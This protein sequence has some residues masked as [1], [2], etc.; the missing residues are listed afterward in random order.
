MFNN[1]VYLDE[2][3]ICGQKFEGTKFQKSS[4]R[5]KHLQLV[6]KITYEQYVIDNF[7]NGVR[8]TCGCGCGEF[9]KFRRQFVDNSWFFTYCQNHRPSK[10]HTQEHKDKIGRGC[11]KTMLEK[12]GVTNPMAVP[13]FKKKQQD[14]VFK[15]YGCTNP[16]KNDK[17]KEKGKKTML[18]RYGV[19]YALQSPEIQKKFKRTSLKKFGVEHPFESEIVKDK[20]KDTIQEKYGSDYY[21]S[22]QEFKDKSIKHFREKYGVDNIMKVKYYID[23]C[24]KNSKKVRFEKYGVEYFLQLPNYKKLYCTSHK[25]KKEIELC[26]K[27]G[28][29]SGFWFNGKEYDIKVGNNLFEIDGD[30]YHV[31]E[32]KNLNLPQLNSCVNDFNKINDCKESPY[33][34]YKIF[35][36]NLPKEIT[37]ENLIK[38]SYVPNF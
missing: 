7:Y 13:K 21:T 14:E 28:G 17:V 5:G 9:P 38:N 6:H 26:E 35:I 29:E 23:L 33:N 1:M 34:L 4:I 10:P 19:E 20:I 25:S 30:Y 31:K 18:K 12:Y 15:K 24:T 22:T 2:C 11:K 8:P 37:Q 27:L 36:S 32:F 16:M 3:S